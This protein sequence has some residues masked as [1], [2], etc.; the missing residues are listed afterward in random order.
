M[1][2]LFFVGMFT[3][4]YAQEA[5][6]HIVINEVDTN[7][8]GDDSKSVSEWVELYNPTSKEVDIGGWKVMSSTGQKKTF[9]LHSGTTIKPGQF[10]VFSYT[11]LWFS[12]VSERVRLLDN[13]GNVV[14]ET[15][16]I[17]D[18]KND[19]TSWQRKFDG[20]DSDATN[21]WVFRMSSAGST[22]GKLENAAAVSS[23]VSIFVNTDKKAYIFGDT[24]IISGNVSKR[25]YQEKPFLTQKQLQV[26]VAGPNNFHKSFSLYPD[27]G[28]E[29][30]TSLKLDKVL[31]VAGGTFIVTA[32][33]DDAQ[34][35]VGFSVGDELPSS[36]IQET[37]E[38]T[39]T[40]DKTQY[41][42][43]QKTLISGSTTHVIPYEGLKYTVYDPKGNQLFT[44]RLYPNPSGDFSV[45]VFMTTVKPVYGIFTLIADY[46]DQHARTTF[47]LV[48][49]IKDTGK[50]VLNTDKEVYGIG[51]PIVITGRSNK[52][53]PALDLEVVQT[54]STAV[55]KTVTNVFKVRDQVK[56]AGDSTFKYTLQIPTDKARTGEYRVTVSKE[57][58]KA[59]TYFRISENPEAPT[60]AVQNV[61]VS[62]DKATYKTGEKMKITGHVAP[63]KSSI[64]QT[65]PVYISIKDESGNP[66]SIIGLNPRSSV[67]N[68]NLAI[69]YTLTAIP[70]AVG[71]YSVETTLN[72]SAFKPGGY[73]IEA[74][75]DRDVKSTVFSVTDGVNTSD[76]GINAVLDKSVYG[77]GETVN[78]Q[79]TLHS[80]ASAVKIVLTKPDGQTV[81]GGANLNNGKFSWSW[82][83]PK[84]DY[85][86]ASLNDNEPR[87]TVFGAYK[88]AISTSSQTTN[89]IFKVSKNPETDTL[90]IKPLDVMT[91]KD[92]YQAGDRLYV[93]GS[94]IKKQQTSSVTGATIPERVSIQVKTSNS[95]V[96]YSGAASFDSLGRFQT[97]YD[98]PL[99]VFKE[100]TYKVSAEYKGLL[101]STTFEVKNNLQVSSSGKLEFSL[102]TDKDTY[103]PGDTVHFIATANKIISISKLDLT[104]GPEQIMNVNCSVLSCGSNANKISLVRYYNNG[105]A[106]YDYKLPVSA[107][108]G[109]Y[110]ATLDAGFGLYSTSFNVVKKSVQQTANTVSE[111]FNRITDPSITIILN[112]KNIENQHVAPQS[113]HGSLV[114]PRGSEKTVNIT[115]TSDD[116][117]CV[118]G[119]LE[120]CLVTSDTSNATGGYREVEF[121]GVSYKVTYSGPDAFL[122]KFS[123]EPSGDTNIPNSIWT[124]DI[125]KNNLPSKFYYEITYVPIQ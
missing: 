83:I 65:N 123:I 4:S 44:G 76:V 52:Y 72:P 121:G 104:V 125:S 25:V 89:L 68:D 42:P 41:I 9:T 6:D 90:E 17:T 57:F 122:E 29:F 105:M 117:A 58:G 47:E 16:I 101:T 119:Q 116:G 86:T 107:E 35:M 40:T 1:A 85:S 54:G 120:G 53:V 2:A 66:L 45:P 5:P 106:S 26:N 79:G 97:S 3:Y 11:S 96:I 118:I 34:D 70:D 59:D 100:G 27:T 80:G 69:Q 92:V 114:I 18:Q 124:A 12:D 75:H 43:G 51:E 14:D 10:L 48:Q 113:I 62:T 60:S 15:P 63:S 74:M 94:A 19:F 46:G 108:L 99:T 61:Y 109:K 49:E 64:L 77:L 84:T 67:T 110:D 91:D 37:S 71:N 23:A 82:T 21:D 8:P 112:D 95:Q 88:I 115:I 73:I 24:A 93:L 31:G 103:S 22:N 39:I 55:G 33:Y 28:L 36:V 87:R 13:L 38:L 50:I 32:S 56:L 20:Y 81:S 78:V 102:R 7:P 30:K 111:K 98:L